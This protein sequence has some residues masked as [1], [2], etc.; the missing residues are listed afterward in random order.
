MVKIT[1]KEFEDVNNKL[2]FDLAFH[3]VQKP[4]KCKAVRVN[5]DKVEL[6]LNGTTVVAYNGD[7][8][9]ETEDKKLI[10]VSSK[11]FWSDYNGL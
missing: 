7:Y 11:L 8:I 2:A 4:K 6:T 1:V 3:C 9:V 5:T 10:P